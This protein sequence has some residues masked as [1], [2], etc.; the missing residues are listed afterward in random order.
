MTGRQTMLVW[1]VALL[2]LLATIGIIVWGI[3][4]GD[5]RSGEQKILCIE[6]GGVWT[7]SGCAWSGGKS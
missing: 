7:T 5:V 2:A 3:N 6:N 1:I 4:Q